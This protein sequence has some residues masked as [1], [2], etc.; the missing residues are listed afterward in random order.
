[1]FSVQNAYKLAPELDQS[2]QR[3]VGGSVKP[4]GSRSMY[5]VIWLAKVLP[6]VHIF[7]W[8]LLHDG[9]AKKADSYG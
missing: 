1:M 3:Q 9:L 6:K 8:R 4:D 2:N 5:N 7:A